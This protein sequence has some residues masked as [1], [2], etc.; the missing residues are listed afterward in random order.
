M[1]CKEITC[2]TPD[3]KAHTVQGVDPGKGKPCQCPAGYKQRQVKVQKGAG[4]PAVKIK[5]KYLESR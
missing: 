1:A 3:G 5:K 4:S 2:I